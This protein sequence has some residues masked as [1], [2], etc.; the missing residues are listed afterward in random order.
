[1]N[2]FTEISCQQARESI[3]DL[4]DGPTD[5]QGAFLPPDATLEAHLEGCSDCRLFRKEMSELHRGLTDLPELEFPDEALEEVWNQT[6]RKSEAARID[7]RWLG[8]AA[9]ILLVVFAGR[10]FDL[11][12]NDPDYSAAEVA[13]ATDEARA[14]LG[15]VRDAL[16]R[17]EHAAIER[18]FGEEVTPALEKITIGLPQMENSKKRRTGA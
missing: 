17:S 16:Q 13:H 11:R 4:L 3:Q 12:E 18:V 2:K 6:V 8:V 7:W 5:G 1:M 9:A 14:A 10:L 15:L